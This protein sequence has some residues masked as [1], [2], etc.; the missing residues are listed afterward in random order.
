MRN[1]PALIVGAGHMGGALVRGCVAAGIRPLAVVEPNPSAQMRSLEKARKISLHKTLEDIGKSRTRVCVIALKPQILKSEAAKLKQVAQSGAL[2]LSIAAGTRIAK[3]A[4]I[5]GRRARIMRAMPNT[6]GAV[7]KGITAI[8]APVNVR[9]ADRKLAASLLAALGEVIWVKRESLLDPVTAVS[10]SGPAYV[11]LMVE[12]LAAAA[13]EQ[14][15]SRAD[16][17]KLARTTIIGSG[18]LLDAD[19]RNAAELRKAVTSP[20]GTTE[21][22]LNILMS[23]HGL[24]NLISRAIAAATKRAEELG[25]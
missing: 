19:P 2:M 16:A 13:E 7:G 17:M 15:F 10:G 25:A 11:F 5:W 6:P 4:K 23:D 21:A 1:G 18:A 12:A 8:Y 3:L 14:G 20:H 22:A 9:P 24:P